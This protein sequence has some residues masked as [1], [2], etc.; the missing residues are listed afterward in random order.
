MKI[1]VLNVIEF[2][3]GKMLIF[4][5]VNVTAL[6]QAVVP[7]HCKLSQK[8]VQTL[9]HTGPDSSYFSCFRF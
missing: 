9:P 1:Q 7:T 2:L 3:E 4:V 6:R 8:M 5:T